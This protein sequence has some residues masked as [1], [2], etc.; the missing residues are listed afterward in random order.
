MARI[1]KFNIDDN[2]YEVG[3][4]ASTSNLGVVKIGGGLSITSEGTL[5]SNSSILYNSTGQNTDGAMTQKAT[6]D[7]LDT[8]ANVSANISTFTNDAGYQTS[9]QVSSAIAAAIGDI[10]ELEYQVVQELPVTGEKGVIYLVPNSGTAP[11][12]Y[13]EYLWLPSGQSGSYEKIGTT[14]VDLSDYVTNSDLS[15][16]LAAYA[17]T[18]SLATVAT[19]G[20]YAD[21]SNKPTIPVITMT[22]T[23]PGEGSA[24]A[25]NN[26]IGVYE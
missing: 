15:T 26:F 2:T 17:T 7:A 9:S 1:E 5:S 16:T 13:D 20:A 8:K 3:K 4:I 25:A 14:A 23:D 19:S 24:L 21:L 12:V 18:A 6:T 10:T 22:T 11:N